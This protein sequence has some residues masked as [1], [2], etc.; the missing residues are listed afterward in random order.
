[1][2]RSICVGLAG[3]A[4][5]AA[6]TGAVVVRAQAPRP[7]G[8]MTAAGKAFLAKLTAEQRAKAVFPFT[9]EERLNW[10]YIPRERKGL[11]LK[12]MTD[13]QKTAALALLR[14]CLSDS[15]YEKTTRVRE[16]DAVLRMKENN[17][18]V[19]DPERYFFELFGE[20]SDATPWG[21]KY[22]GHHCSLNWTIV[23]GKSASSPQFYGSNPATVDVQAPGGPPVGTRALKDE[24]DF[25]LKLVNSLTE[26]QKKAAIQAGEVPGDITTTNTRQIAI[27]ESQGIAYTA[28][29]ADQ[30]ATF[31]S[32]VGAYVDNQ[33][34]AVA[35]DRVQKIIASGPENV[36]FG[37]IG[38]T[39]AGKHYYYRVQGPTFLI[40]FDN[41]NGNH[42]HCVWRDAKD[43]FGLDLL[44]LHY[45]GDRHRIAAR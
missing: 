34:E 37:W 3:L 12:E 43:D 10:H 24:E 28:L 16:L 14:A 25:G 40:E 11:P 13:E 44:A 41:V 7:E 31:R 18:A 5:L 35:R 38:P 21:F 2:R 22:E 9:S 33:P 30:Q 1:M 29:T 20:P 19:R 6:V 36:K 8:A 15:G 39:E 32:L 26:D 27:K 17:A 45:R 23:K 42:I 4:G